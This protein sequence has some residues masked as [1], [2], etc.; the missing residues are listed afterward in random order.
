MPSASGGKFLWHRKGLSLE[1]RVNYFRLSVRHERQVVAFLTSKQAPRTLERRSELGFFRAALAW[2]QRLLTRYAAKLGPALP[3][4]YQQWLCIHGYEG[5][6]TDAG[7]PFWG[8]L[9]FGWNE[10]QRFGGRY[11][12]TANLASPLEQMWAAEAYWQVS[13]FRPWPR[14]ARMCG[15]L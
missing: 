15:L 11:A 12:P 14:T 6:W 8:G 13:G 9:Q 4:H 2:H 10:W 7:A 5:S 1:Q 3:P